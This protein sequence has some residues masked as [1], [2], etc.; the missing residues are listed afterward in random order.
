MFKTVL[1][2]ETQ[3]RMSAAGVMI[4][5]HV[6]PHN[7]GC[8]FTQ[9]LKYLEVVAR[10]LTSNPDYICLYASHLKQNKCTATYYNK[11]DTRPRPPTAS[12]LNLS[13]LYRGVLSALEYIFAACQNA[14]LYR[15][16][17][18]LD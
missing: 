5:N 8:Q 3:F 4:D 9:L 11:D 17:R 1:I 18:I 14:K 13:P 15:T 7:N 12:N 10:H 16:R 6:Q 2:S